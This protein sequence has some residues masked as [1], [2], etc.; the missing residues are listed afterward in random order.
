MRNE[1]MTRGRRPDDGFILIEAAV[2]MVVIMM[3]MGAVTTFFISSARLVREQQNAEVAAQLATTA[4]TTV[5][6][7]QGASLITGRDVTSST[8]Q[9]GSLTSALTPYLDG[10]VLAYDTI[11]AAGSGATA[12]LPTVP[13]DTVVRGL[14]YHTS[15]Y[16]GSCWQ[17]SA[18]GTC[19]RTTVPGGVAMYRV[20]VAVT[21]TDNACVNSLCTY[22]DAALVS[23]ALIDPIF[24]QSTTSGGS[25]SMSAGPFTGI[26]AAIPNTIQA[27]DYDLGGQGS[28]YNFLSS[29][30]A[31]YRNDNAGIEGTSD[32]IGNYDVSWTAAG[33]WYRYTLNPVYAG[34]Y[35][36]TARVAAASAV[37]DAFHLENAAGVNISGNIDLPAT[38]GMQTWTTTTASA[39]FALSTGSQ[40]VKLVQDH[41]G[42]NINYLVFQVDEHPYS[43]TPAPIPGLLQ[44][45]DYDTGG[46]GVGYSIGTTNNGSGYRVDYGNIGTTSDPAGGGYQVGWTSSGYWYR[47]TVNVAVAGTYSIAYRYSAPSAVT[48]SFHL[49]NTAGTTLG[50]NI[51]LTATASWTT[52]NTV[53]STITLPAGQQVLTLKEDRG[54]WNLNYLTFS[55]LSSVTAPSPAGY[56]TII[57][58]NSNSCVESAN[59]GTTNGTALDQSTCTGATSQGWQ[60]VSV[61]SGIYQVVNR[62]AQSQNQSWD[63]TGGASAL[64]AGTKIQTNAYTGGAD[65]KW[66]LASLGNGWF[67]FTVTSSTMCLTVTSAAIANGTA[68]EQDPCINAASQTFK[69]TLQP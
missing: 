65:Q 40:T 51:N 69:L 4:M 19:N 61:G 59:A 28:A 25:T 53:T 48:D 68:L 60:F 5:H 21:W 17:P 43:G 13:V 1:P 11:A 41:G 18:G 35:T 14:T 67:E 26:P 55:S 33:Q 38:G 6:T 15:Y 34:T 56:Y 30:G 9:W 37:P 49:T 46:Q 63:V 66:Q 12:A 42:W 2:A 52:Y 39:G 23:S 31:G 32:T 36:I 47:Y 50:S 10:S 20:V 29:S 44:A 58:Q 7:I 22:A 54:G 64:T 57:S 27:E 24:N 3:V 45:E 62:N 8:A 16:I